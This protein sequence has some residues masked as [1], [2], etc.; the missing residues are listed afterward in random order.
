MA[1]Q[2]FSLSET[3]W[4]NQMS[5]LVCLCVREREGVR[6]WGGGWYAHPITSPPWTIPS[7]L[8]CFATLEYVQH[9]H[10]DYPDVSVCVSVHAYVKES[11]FIRGRMVQRP[12]PFTSIQLLF[13]IGDSSSPPPP[14]PWLL[15]M[16]EAYW[17]WG[18]GMECVEKGGRDRKGTW[19]QAYKYFNR[20]SLENYQSSPKN[21]TKQC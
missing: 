12:P 9:F 6:V 7:P 8:K 19:W 4:C 18:G 3:T 17:W 11:W 15:S 10:R 21:K 14:S 5:G 20:F 13:V 2:C 1:L 16:G